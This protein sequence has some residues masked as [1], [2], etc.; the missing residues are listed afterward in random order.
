VIWRGANGWYL[1]QTIGPAARAGAVR[2]AQ[3]AAQGTPL[4][5]VVARH[6]VAAKL[7]NMRA[8][9]RRRLAAD[10]A[11]GKADQALAA[12]L[13]RVET[14]SELDTL[15]GLEGAAAAAYFACWPALLRGRA[16]RLGFPGRNRRP[17]GDPLNA[18]LS[19][20][21]AVLTGECA[22]AALAAG[23]DPTEGFL[24]AARAGRPALALDLLEPF[25]P[26]VADATVLFV[27]NT[28][29]LDVAAFVVEADG[30]RLTEAGRRTLLHA[31]ERR[32]GQRFA[33]P[34]GA[35]IAWRDAIGRLAA[36]L[37]RALLAGTAD[38]LV[39]PTRR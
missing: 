14:Q 36:S 38:R 22:T 16:V 32:L 37:A 21:Y 33:D 15:R 7:A 3:Y 8:L 9:L 11:V 18:A 5:F 29:E 31:L 30:V 6:L 27:F 26:A 17:P 35:E 23:L 19:Y 39:V 4:G 10:T 20:A 24:H 25:R 13:R 28:G 12:L 34:R 1:G 2:R